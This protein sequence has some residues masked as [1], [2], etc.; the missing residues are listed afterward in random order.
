MKSKATSRQKARQPEPVNPP[1]PPR[2]ELIPGGSRHVSGRILP[3][4]RTTLPVRLL[5]RRGQV[6]TRRST[7]DSYSPS[8]RHLQA[9]TT[10]DV[11]GS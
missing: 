9:G 10:S 7:P 1:D 5:P 8:W 3:Q 6:Y 2:W 4:R 11:R